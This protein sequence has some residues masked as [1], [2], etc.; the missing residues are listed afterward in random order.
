VV[1][2]NV[3]ST[4]G[5]LTSELT[6]TSITV[7]A[8]LVDGFDI[9]SNVSGGASDNKASLFTYGN[10]LIQVTEPT[11]WVLDLFVD[12]TLSSSLAVAVAE[13]ILT[14]P[15][16]NAPGCRINLVQHSDPIGQQYSIPFT[17]NQGGFWGLAYDMQFGVR[18]P[19]GESG[20]TLSDG[21][22]EMSFA[23]VPAPAVPSLSPLAI[24]AISSLMGLVG[25][26]RLRA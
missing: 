14:P 12:A 23:M 10:L 1:T 17:M 2:T 6:P 13:V 20:A 7:S 21:V 25:W 18:S 8:P 9:G 3:G 11:D 16:C 22:I 26:R 5:S 4:S 24:A 15:G 19:P